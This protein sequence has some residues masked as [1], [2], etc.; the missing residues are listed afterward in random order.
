MRTAPN[1]TRLTLRSTC[2]RKVGM[3]SGHRAR[4]S[5]P[6]V[7]DNDDIVRAS[8]TVSQHA[9]ELCDEFHDTLPT[10]VGCYLCIH[11]DTS[12]YAEGIKVRASHCEA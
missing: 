12:Q 1:V 2:H 5:L 3:V 7:Q 4:S 6:L 10:V 9:T 8:D 11:P